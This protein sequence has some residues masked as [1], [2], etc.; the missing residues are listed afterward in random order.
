MVLSFNYTFCPSGSCGYADRN[1]IM[2][3]RVYVVVLL[4]GGLRWGGISERLQHTVRVYAQLLMGWK[5][6][7]WSRCLLVLTISPCFE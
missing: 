7:E 6:N 5:V 4:G 3:E 1:K 2:V